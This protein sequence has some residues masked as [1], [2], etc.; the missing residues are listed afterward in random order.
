MLVR[1]VRGVHSTQLPGVA[2]DREKEL[3]IKFLEYFKRPLHA[4]NI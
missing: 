2:R 4:I 3:K 1:A